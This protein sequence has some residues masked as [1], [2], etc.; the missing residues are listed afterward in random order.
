MRYRQG[1]ILEPTN[2]SRCRHWR[3]RQLQARVAAIV[4]AIPADLLRL[5]STLVARDVAQVFGV[6]HRVAMSAVLEARGRFQGGV[7]L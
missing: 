6:T 7:T 1:E 5:S 4:P 2:A 3:V